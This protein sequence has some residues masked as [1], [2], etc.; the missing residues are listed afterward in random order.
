MTQD[1]KA[2]FVN[3]GRPMPAIHIPAENEPP[4]PAKP[5]KRSVSRPFS[6]NTPV[7]N[8]HYTLLV[9]LTEHF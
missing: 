6:I 1:L 9:R 7:T 4:I 3:R 5:E 2:R 8:A